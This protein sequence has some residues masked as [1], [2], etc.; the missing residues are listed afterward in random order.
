MFCNLPLKKKKKKNCEEF[1]ESAKHMKVKN[2][3]EYN[4]LNAFGYE[5][6]N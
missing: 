2:F 4:K 3:L 5:K 1:L 6:K